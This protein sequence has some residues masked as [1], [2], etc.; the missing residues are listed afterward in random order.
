MLEDD[1]N[2]NKEMKTFI[3]DAIL[4][5]DIDVYSAG[6]D[7]LGDN[8]PDNEMVENIVEPVRRLAGAIAH[9][10]DYVEILAEQLGVDHDMMKKICLRKYND[11]KT[12]VEDI[13]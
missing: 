12:E 7:A 8:D 13:N 10:L 3:F 1:I 4:Q 6:V 5:I 2:V 9:L 11:L